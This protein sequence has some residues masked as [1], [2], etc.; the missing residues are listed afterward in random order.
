MCNTGPTDSNTRA[1]TKFITTKVLSRVETSNM[2]ILQSKVAASAISGESGNLYPATTHA[3]FLQRHQ[4]SLGR[5]TDRIV[6]ELEKK[7]DATKRK[8]VKVAKNKGKLT[9]TKTKKG[10]N[11]MGAVCEQQVVDEE[12]QYEI[13]DPQSRIF[14]L[15]MR[16]DQRFVLASSLFSSLTPESP[17]SVTDDAQTASVDAL[18]TY[19][20]AIELS[21]EHLVPSDI[22]RIQLTI[23]T[24]LALATLPPYHAHDGWIVGKKGLIRAEKYLA[25]DSIVSDEVVE[26]LECL[27]GVVK[28]L[29]EKV[30]CDEEEGENS[31]RRA[32]ANE[33]SLVLEDNTHHEKDGK[34]PKIQSS[35]KTNGRGYSDALNKMVQRVEWIKSVCRMPTMVFDDL[36]H[37]ATI[38]K[39]LRRLFNSY[40]RGNAVHAEMKSGT[41]CDIS[42]Q[43]IDM[44]DYLLNG[45]FLNWDGFLF[46][47]HDFHILAR[48]DGKG[49]RKVNTRAGEEF[50]ANGSGDDIKLCFVMS[51]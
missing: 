31:S 25:S 1:T 47:L 22:L 48:R 5:V 24:S 33:Q 30:A 10:Q 7:I 18:D 19:E 50:L 13:I 2:S 15:K 34:L 12:D 27:R 3:T 37:C 45:P 21:N 40:V 29:E 6:G 44:D 11:K 36:D 28:W 41:Y 39:A 51:R 4:A 8:K 16:A 14:F 46:M 20:E 9:K 26:A 42:G 35:L 43:V 17:S 49:G 38:G 23:K 32:I